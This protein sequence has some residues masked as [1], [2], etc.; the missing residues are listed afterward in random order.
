MKTVFP[1]AG[2]QWIGQTLL[3]AALLLPFVLVA[4]AGAQSVGPERE[5][6]CYSW[7]FMNSTGQDADDLHAALRTVRTVTSVYEADDNVFGAPL[8][9]SGYDAT[10]DAYRLEY[11]GGPALDATPN[12]IG[13]CADSDTLRLT[14]PQQHA[15]FYWTA[16]GAPLAPAP[17]F[18][19]VS[20]T[21]LGTG[22]LRIT[23]Y[24]DQSTALTLWSA[25]LLVAAEPLPLTDLHAD[26]LAL[27]PALAELNSDVV[28]LQPG[29]TLAVTIPRPALTGLPARGALVLTAEF[30]RDGDDGDAG[31]LYAQ[32]LLPEPTY[33]PLIL[34]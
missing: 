22:G 3:V 2:P 34:R 29:E 31:H 10:L 12:H 18:L 25:A 14:D 28:V 1:R 16:G 30:A 9:A 5:T 24:N 17:V 4:P 27:L 13:V 23:L 8:P 15:G 33:L 32:L 6:F 19:G 20:W 11:G 26:A 21:R 7:D